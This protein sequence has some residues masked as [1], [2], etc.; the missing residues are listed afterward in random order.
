[1]CYPGVGFPV[2]DMQTMKGELNVNFIF[3]FKK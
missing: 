3:S 1:M 2:E